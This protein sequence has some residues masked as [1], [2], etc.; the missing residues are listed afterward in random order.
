MAKPTNAPA[1][2]SWR[3]LS[4]TQRNY[5]LVSGG[6]VIASLRFVKTLGTLAEAQIKG[7]TYSFKRIGFIHPKITIRKA[8][9]EQDIGAVEMSWRGTGTAVM[10]NGRRYLLKRA[11]TWG[12]KWEVLDDNGEALATMKLRR[13]FL[14]IEA[15]VS[16]HEKGSRDS[17]LVLMLAL[18]LYIVVLIQ[19]DSAAAAAES[20]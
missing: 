20:S 17:D 12:G 2:L 4:A 19:Q 7:V 5:E 1:S 13:G 11:S 16:V 10:N 18:E 15:D 6:Q 14:R 8:P 3:Q 9:F